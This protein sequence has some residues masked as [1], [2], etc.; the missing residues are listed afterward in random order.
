MRELLLGLPQHP[1]TFFMLLLVSL[2]SIVGFYYRPWYG[3]CV[4]HPY[5]VWR[6]KRRW[7]VL[8]MALVHNSWQHLILNVFLLLVFSTSLEDTL[9]QTVQYGYLVYSGMLLSCLLTGNLG[10]TIM[11]KNDFGFSTSGA[12]NC[13]LGLFTGKFLITPLAIVPLWS[14][15]GDVY[16][17]HIG[18][19]LLILH[20]F[21]IKMRPNDPFDHWGHLFGSLTGAL[22]GFSIYLING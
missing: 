18:I 21:A 6:G 16:Y 10:T 13:L 19:Y 12:S 4:L 22:L 5:S 15:V 14:F 2:S 3:A 7:T 20:V 9:S 1:A 17:W 8:T 11:N